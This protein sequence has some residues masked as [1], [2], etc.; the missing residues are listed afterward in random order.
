[1]SSFVLKCVLVAPA[2]VGC[3]LAVVTCLP[4]PLRHLSGVELDQNIYCLL[5]NV[6]A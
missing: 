3:V 5:S 2:D 4:V 6:K 1:M